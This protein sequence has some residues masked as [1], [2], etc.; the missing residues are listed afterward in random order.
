MIHVKE[1]V[2]TL[3]CIVYK[4]EHFVVVKVHLKDQRVSV[5]DSAIPN[6]A[7]DGVEISWLP[8]IVYLIRVHFPK[9]VRYNDDNYP[10]NIL[11]TRFEMKKIGRIVGR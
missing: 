3:L 8:H 2:T 10:A 1:G 4:G 9:K 7:L 6:D 5:W 11:M